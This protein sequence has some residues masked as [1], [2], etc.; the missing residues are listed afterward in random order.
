MKKILLTIF[1]S[2]T[3]SLSIAQS[4]FQLIIDA[5]LNESTFHQPNTNTT[6][7]SSVQQN[8]YSN[9]TGFHVGALAE[10]NI[11]PVSIQT[12]LEY[13]VKGSNGTEY[14]SQTFG[15]GA[16]AYTTSSS[17]TSTEKL[18]YYEI[19]LNILY[20]I[21]INKTEKVFVGGGPYIA[22]GSSGKYSNSGTS[23][24]PDPETGINTV[25]PLSE[26]QAIAF[27]SSGDVQ[28]TD[29]GINAIAGF[30]YK[31]RLLFS[32]GYGFGLAN[33][34]TSGVKTTNNVMKVSLGYSFF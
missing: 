27:G 17:L 19:P 9:L 7:A 12:G 3:I 1:L 10:F 8:S 2:G 26:S 34:A 30:S 29:Y 15:S 28:T 25:T 21:P 18:N 33:I 32:L 23:I 11:Y 22:F 14:N 16:T 24:S 5:G 4:T 6:T 13:T 20:N 31:N